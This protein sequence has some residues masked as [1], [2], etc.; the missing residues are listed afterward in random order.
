MPIRHEL[1]VGHQADKRFGLKARNVSVDVLEDTWLEHEEP[2]VDPPFTNLRLLSEFGDDISLEH[3]TAEPGRRS[4]G[5]HGRQ[6]PVRAMK[7]EEP[8]DIDIADAVA[9]GGHESPI[10][11]A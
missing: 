2:A 8:A 1:A 5:R 3:H 7:P 4:Y 10:P 6:P 9:V 11:E